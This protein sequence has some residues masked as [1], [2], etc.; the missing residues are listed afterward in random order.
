MAYTINAALINARRIASW[1]SIC[2]CFQ[3]NS[4][5]R[6]VHRV[7]HNSLPAPDNV[8]TNDLVH[9]SPSAVAIT[10]HH[11]YVACIESETRCTDISQPQSIVSK[12]APW[13]PSCA[14]LHRRNCHRYLS[15]PSAGPLNRHTAALDAPHGR[16]PS[17]AA[18][19]IS[20]AL[21]AMASAIGRPFAPW[22]ALPML[23]LPVTF[24][25]SRTC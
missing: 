22:R 16:A 13:N 14:N 21:G 10:I 11:H 19:S 4:P 18:S 2:A 24:T 3:H 7:S 8:Q 9:F 17:S 6:N 25:F 5:F 15:A 20:P 12:R 23:S 1:S